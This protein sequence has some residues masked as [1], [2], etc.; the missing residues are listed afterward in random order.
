MTELWQYI[1]A[2]HDE[3]RPRVFLRLA[4]LL[5]ALGFLHGDEGGTYASFTWCW[6][7]WRQVPGP[8]MYEKGWRHYNLSWNHPFR[9]LRRQGALRNLF[10]Y[11][12]SILPPD[13]S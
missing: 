5:V 12:R 6:T 3:G 7:F 13:N 10:G 1:A 9:K 4:G 8:E 11:S 2:A